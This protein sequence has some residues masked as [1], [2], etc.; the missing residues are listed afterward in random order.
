[1]ISALRPPVARALDWEPIRGAPDYLFSAETRAV[2]SRKTGAMLKVSDLGQVQVRTAR[3]RRRYVDIDALMED[4][5][6]SRSAS[7]SAAPSAVPSAVPS[8]TPS[9]AP[10][11]TPR[12]G[13]GAACASSLGFLALVLTASSAVAL[14]TDENWTAEAKE[15]IT[16]IYGARA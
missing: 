2:M 9:A 8:A 11:E 15:W 10:L 14:A 3:G 1:M 6:A 7:P 13:W 12:R 16:A 5:E 4:R